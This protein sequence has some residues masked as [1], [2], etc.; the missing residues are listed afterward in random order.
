VRYNWDKIFTFFLGRYFAV[1]QVIALWAIFPLFGPLIL[2]YL[3]VVLQY[4]NASVFAI[5]VRHVNVKDYHIE[6][7]GWMGAHCLDSHA[8]IVALS[9]LTEVLLEKYTVNLQQEFV[10]V[11]Y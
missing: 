9:N 3:M 2:I 1:Q 10:V 8:S 5:H 11:C 7:I 4:L 6:V